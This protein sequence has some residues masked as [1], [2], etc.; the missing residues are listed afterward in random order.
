MYRTSQAWRYGVIYKD[1][2]DFYVEERA[3]RQTTNIFDENQSQINN[4]VSNSSKVLIGNYDKYMFD[5]RP[6][7]FIGEKTRRKTFD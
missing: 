3:V 6:N 4:R 7:Q 1:F 2:R 5:K